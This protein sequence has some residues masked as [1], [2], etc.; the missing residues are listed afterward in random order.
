MTQQIQELL[1]PN[2]TAEQLLEL[3]GDLEIAKAAALQ[4][5]IALS[6]T[7]QQTEDRLLNVEEAA[8]R[9]GMSTDYLYR[10]KDKFPFTRR[11]GRKLLFSSVGI[12]AYIRQRRK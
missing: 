10:H 7:P 3:I 1:A 2:M 9:L 8:E 12:D 4:R 5:L 6:V 11:M